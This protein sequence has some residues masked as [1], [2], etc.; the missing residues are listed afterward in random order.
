MERD[1]LKV[2]KQEIGDESLDDNADGED[3]NFG[4][5]VSVKAEPDPGNTQYAEAL[6][7]TGAIE[8]DVFTQDKVKQETEDADDEV[9]EGTQEDN[10]AY[11]ESAEKKTYT[12]E[13]CHKVM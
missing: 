9:D 1:I 4:P 6:Y 8:Q 12:C 13:Y 3:T 11:L 10:K 2:I 5:E 7:L